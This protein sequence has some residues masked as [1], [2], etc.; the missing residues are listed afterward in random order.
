AQAPGAV[1]SR[2]WPFERR[3]RA[4]GRPQTPAH[5]ER[6]T[7]RARVVRVRSRRGRGDGGVR[8]VAR[9]TATARAWRRKSAQV[10]THD[11]LLAERRWHPKAARLFNRS[12]K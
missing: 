9:F 2:A 7:G 11:L 1:G 12:E 3:L 4:A 10:G 5:A 6:P 8:R